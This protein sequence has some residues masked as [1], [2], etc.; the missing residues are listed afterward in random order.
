MD[1][2]KN[3]KEVESGLVKGVRGKGITSPI[4]KT[5]YEN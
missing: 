3:L 2:P 1:V 4:N 5:T